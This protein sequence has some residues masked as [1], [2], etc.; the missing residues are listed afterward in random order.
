MTQS[1]NN[2]SSFEQSRL[3]FYLSWVRAVTVLATGK[4]GFRAA[5]Q[6]SMSNP[7]DSGPLQLALLSACGTATGNH[8]TPFYFSPENQIF[9]VIP[10]YTPST[11]YILISVYLTVI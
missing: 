6:H 3:V 11:Y 9:K 1:Q 2:L 5:S 8:K 7:V 10:T 4:N